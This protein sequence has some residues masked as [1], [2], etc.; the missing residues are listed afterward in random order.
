[1]GEKR[2][3]DI[4]RKAAVILLTITVMVVSLAVLSSGSVMA[5]SLS[6]SDDSITTDNGAVTGATVS[7]NT[8]ITWDGA[9]NEPGQTDVKLQVKNPD[10]DWETLSV[11][12]TNLTGLAGQYNP[13][14]TSV[15]ITDSDY[16]NGDFR[17]TGDGTSNNVEL[18]FRLVVET[19]GHLDGD[20]NRQ[21]STIT[22]S[23][24]TATVTAVNEA[25]SNGAGGSGGVTVT[26]SNNEP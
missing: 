6:I 24:E 26:G 3:R 8:D 20:D 16:N 10:G 14:F 12:S 22:S 1:M 19:S 13:S 9:E 4:R 7:L 5:A 11:K 18:D 2:E 23:T 21:T 25:N 15:D 17:A